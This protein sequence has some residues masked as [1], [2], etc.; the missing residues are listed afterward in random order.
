MSKAPLTF[1]G[2]PEADKNCRS[3]LKRFRV[4]RIGTGIFRNS[5]SSMHDT[6]APVSYK[7]FLVWFAIEASRKGLP[8]RRFPAIA[9]VNN[10]MIVFRKSEFCIGRRELGAAAPPVNSL[11]NPI[12]FRWSLPLFRCP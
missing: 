11:K 3:W 12:H 6:S 7:T 10:V 9:H 1:N 4:G 5:F 2:S 8:V